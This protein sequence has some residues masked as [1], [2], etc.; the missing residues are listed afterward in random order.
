[1]YRLFC[2]S[3]RKSYFSQFYR[4]I[5]IEY[6]THVISVMSNLSYICYSINRLSLIGQDHG[7]FV[8]KVSKMKLK[9]FFL[10]TFLFCL[11]LPIPKIFTFK[12]NYFRFDHNYPD[13]L[14]F[15]DINDALIF[16]YLSSSILYNLINLIGFIVANLVVDINLLFSMKKVIAERAKNTSRAVQTNENSKK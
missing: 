12:P 10:I 4:I 16:L 2:S 7:K 5:F 14:D 8:K 9:K 3:A 1:M 15:S 13:F 6:L 11:A